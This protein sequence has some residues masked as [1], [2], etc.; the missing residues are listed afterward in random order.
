[1]SATVIKKYIPPKGRRE[2][3]GY[4]GGS[5]STVIS[6]QVIVNGGSGG[7]TEYQAGTGIS[8][9]NGIISCTLSPGVVYSP[10]DNITI[11]G[12]V[13]SSPES[14]QS[15]SVKNILPIKKSDF[16]ALTAKSMDTLYLV[17]EPQPVGAF[18]R[19]EQIQDV[20]YNGAVITDNTFLTYFNYNIYVKF[21]DDST[22]DVTS[23]STIAVN[24][25]TA[26]DIS[27]NTSSERILA[28]Q[29]LVMGY[30]PETYT[31][32]TVAVSSYIQIYQ[33]G[34]IRELVS[35]RLEGTWVTDVP[36]SGGVITSGNCS[37]NLYYIYSDSTEE[38]HTHYPD[39]Y[40]PIQIEVGPNTTGQRKEL[41]GFN[42]YVV[43]R[44]QSPMTSIYASA[45]IIPYQEAANTN[46]IKY[47][48]SNDSAITPDN[49]TGFGANIVS[50][51]YYPDADYGEI[52]FDDNV[53]VIGQEAFYHRSALSA[54]IIPSTVTA[55]GNY[56]FD[57]CSFSSITIP[58]SVVSIG[59]YAFRYNSHLQSIVISSGITSIGDSVLGIGIVAGCTSLSS[60]TVNSAN[61]VYDS[62]DN[63][64]A[65]IKTSTNS[66]IAGCLS[67]VIPTSVTVIDKQAF[68]SIP[69]TSITIPNS[70]TEINSQA[71]SNSDLINIVIPDSVTTLGN[72]IFYGCLSLSSVTIGSGVSSLSQNMFSYC[73]ALNTINYSGTKSQWNNLAKYPY[74]NRNVPATV[75][76]CSDGDVQL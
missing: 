66:L 27:A 19:Y 1:M 65:I 31:S 48:S 34:L 14:V 21:S 51:T 16:D 15:P 39:F 36:A 49:T 50:N 33:A 56:A 46:K 69:I 70:V 6:N 44:R 40:Y 17:Y 52:I 60:I 26:I 2:Y 62:R 75:V 64:N 7:N 61:T 57:G 41:D 74:W 12:S 45:Y 53:T 43:V 35:A 5:G 24:N 32:T 72:S 42:A 58:D 11:S 23:A 3:S 20:P 22:I 55:I 68:Q 9:K 54:I 47:V 67:T 29:P 25:G 37:W 28:A 38:L 8:I 18:V 63:C 73:S 71:F 76:H 13:I 4:E 30:L 10:G 59:C